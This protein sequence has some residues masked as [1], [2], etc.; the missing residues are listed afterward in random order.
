MEEPVI[1]TTL[2]QLFV[3]I[4]PSG[5]GLGLM[6]VVCRSPWEIFSGIHFFLV[7]Q[8]LSNDASR[9][10]L[11][12][13][14]QTQGRNQSPCRS[15]NNDRCDNFLFSLLY[16][17]LI[18]TIA[19]AG[20]F[21][22]GDGEDTVISAY[23]QV[24]VSEDSFAVY[25]SMQDVSFGNLVEYF[26][27]GGVELPPVV[28]NLITVGSATVSFNPSA[29][30]ASAV[31]A[32]TAPAPSDLVASSSSDCDNAFSLLSF[33]PLPAGVYVDVRY[34]SILDGFIV[35]KQATVIV[36]PSN[37]LY[38]AV[39]LEKITSIPGIT[40]TDLS[41]STGPYFYLSLL[42]SDFNVTFSGK[43]SFLGFSVGATFMINEDT[44][45]AD[46]EI[47]LVPG[48]TFDFNFAFH[49]TKPSLG[50]QFLAEYN[51]PD[52]QLIKAIVAGINQMFDELNSGIDSAK[53]V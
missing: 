43:F 20:G 49:P 22:L 37:G 38:V 19:F 50:F 5:P 3:D 2:V 48:V 35:I 7:F 53:Q 41:G 8:W 42:K 51:D 30:T 17:V 52:K 47:Q 9:G 44:V 10:L 23:S 26:V 29:S 1:V 39:V 14:C 28:A 11:G 33:A 27:G 31:G 40:I 12:V 45:M 32:S 24:M 4:G 13:S 25:F 18:A 36:D 34:M 15:T 21:Q 16:M 6:A 46:T